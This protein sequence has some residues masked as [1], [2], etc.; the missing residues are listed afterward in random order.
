M[1]FTDNLLKNPYISTFPD[2]GCVYN[3][4]LNLKKA[5]KIF[6]EKQRQYNI[7]KLVFEL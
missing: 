1:R 6:R 7:V 3:L 2:C 4:A 5:H